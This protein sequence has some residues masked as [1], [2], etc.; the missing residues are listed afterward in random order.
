MARRQSSSYPDSSPGQSGYTIDEA[1][2]SYRRHLLAGGRTDATVD[3]T[4]VPRLVKFRSFLATRG[5]PQSVRAIRRP[6]LDYATHDPGA[7]QPDGQRD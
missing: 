4:Y 2:P 5:L 3:R 1:I 7:P 6:E